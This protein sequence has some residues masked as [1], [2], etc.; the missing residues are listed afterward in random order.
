MKLPR[1]L[2]SST[3]LPFISEHTS[4]IRLVRGVAGLLAASS[5]VAVVGTIS[6]EKAHALPF[7]PSPITVGTFKPPVAS[8]QTVPPT[9][10]VIKNTIVFQTVPPTVV[11]QT[12]PP[13]VAATVPKPTVVI[14]TILAQPPGVSV[15]VTAG[16]TGT[17]PATLPTIPPANPSS[18]AVPLSP[19]SSV[20]TLVFAPIDQIPLVTLPPANGPAVT[21]VPKSIPAAIAKPT[22]VA[23][24][25]AKKSVARKPVKKKV[26]AKKTAV[27][28]RVLKK[29][30]TKR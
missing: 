21:A 14:N 6:S 4:R 22:L 19:N 23:K 16:T 8:Y 10:G 12:V 11:F 28:K 17:T 30:S 29:A 18:E 15:P 1:T 3:A 25:T 26:V 20:P 7:G 13:T 24:S 2:K 5:L 27:T 9:I